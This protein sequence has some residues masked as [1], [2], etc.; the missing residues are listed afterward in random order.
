[1]LGDNVLGTG[2]DAWDTDTVPIDV[3]LV[4]LHPFSFFVICHNFFLLKIKRGPRRP[5][6]CGFAA[7]LSDLRVFRINPTENVTLVFGDVLSVK[8]AFNNLSFIVLQRH[9]GKFQVPSLGMSSAVEAELCDVQFIIP[10]VSVVF[11][12]SIFFL[13]WIFLSF[14]FEFLLQF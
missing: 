6:F 11:Y 2:F 7:A 10:P 8:I 5:P 9:L 13:F 12:F 4:A 1:V 3:E 14:D